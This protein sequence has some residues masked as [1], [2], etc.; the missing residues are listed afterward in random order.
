[1]PNA[2]AI[3]DKLTKLGGKVMNKPMD[4]PNVGRF[5]PAMDPQGAAVAFLA[6]NT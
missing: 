5:F 4:V 1:V 3:A 2:D 6:P